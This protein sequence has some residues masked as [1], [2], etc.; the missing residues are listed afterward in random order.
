MGGPVR[1]LSAYA[2]ITKDIKVSHTDENRLEVVVAGYDA[3]IATRTAANFMRSK[4]WDVQLENMV[5]VSVTV[6]RAD[7]ILHDGVERQL[8]ADQ[9]DKLPTPSRHKAGW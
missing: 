6:I 3:E 1:R 7:V 8:T 9:L 2:F 5:L 4:G